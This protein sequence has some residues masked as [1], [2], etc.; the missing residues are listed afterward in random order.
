MKLTKKLESEILKVYNGYWDSYFKGDMRAFASLLHENVQLI[1]TSE[2]EVFSNKRSA[3][4]FYKATAGQVTG[5]AGMQNRKITMQVV[6]S[7]VLV[8]EQSDFYVLIDNEWSFYGNGRLS[9]LLQKTDAGWK[10]IHEHGSLPDSKTGEGE[11]VNTEKI[12]E[13]NRQLREAV[14]RRTI[15]LENK[16]RELE[17]ET[18]LERVRVVSMGMRKPDDMLDVCKTIS[19]QLQSLGVKEI[20]NVQTAI[21]YEQSGTYMNYEYYSKHKKTF[22]T[23]TDY[24]NNK[25]HKTFA[26]KMLKGKGETFTSHIKSK[27]LKEWI[28]Y[29]KTTNVFIDKY[30]NKAS[31]L[32]YY[33][34]SLGPVALGISTYHPL[35]EEE[36]DLF[37]RF[38]KVFELAYRRYLDIEKAEAQ[39][40]EAKIEAALERVR[41]RTM[42][43]QKSE[44][45]KEVIRVVY[46]QFVHLKF[47]VHHAGFVV[48][49]TAKG[50][51]HFW[52]ADEQDI[53]SKITHPYFESVWASQFNEAKEKGTDFFATKLNFEEKN[54]FYNELLSYVPGLPETSK[55]FYLS[56]P[57]LAA[58][59]VLLENVSLYIENFSGIQ[60][61][62]EENATLMR[63]GK[64]FQQTYTR[65]LDLQK[66]ET[67]AREA[68]IE[69]SLEKVR[70]VALTMKKSDE[71]LD[72]AQVLYEQLLELGFNNIRNAIIDLHNEKDKTFLDYDYSHDMGR[73]ITLM[74]YYDDPIIEKQVRQIESSSDAFFEIILE[75]QELQDLID[76]RLKNGEEE[77]PRLRQINQLTYNL[78]SFGNGAIGISNFGLLS[79]E[80]KI[81][82]KRFRN[83]FAFAYK[84]YNDMLQ[85]EAQAKESIKQASLDRVRG[86]IASMRTTEDLNRITP[87]IWRELKTLEVPFIRCGIFIVDEKQ[88]KVQVYL[89]TPDGKSLAV[90]NLPFDSNTLTKNTVNF[91]RQ[92]KVYQEHWNKEEFINWI[93]SMMDLRQVEKAETYQGSSNP[94]ES[95]H[96][97]FVPFTQ[98]MLYVGDVSPLTDE[99]L[100]LVKTLAEAFSIAYARYEDFKNLEDAKNRIEI[101]LSELKSAQTQLVHSEKMASLGELTAGIAHEIK[102]PLNFVNNFSEISGELINEIEDELQKNNKE[103]V[104]AILKDLKQN[105]ERINQHGKRADSIVKG[106][107]LHSRGTSGEKT[108][109]DI[110][111]LLDQYVILTYH[112]LRAQNSEF[113]IAIEKDYDETLGKINVVPQDISRVFLNIINNACYAAY[114]KKQK[115]KNDFH[116]ILTVSTKNLQNKVEIRI[117]DNGYGIPADVLD[118]IFQPFFT[119]K[120]TGEGTG[121]GL[122][123]SY[124]IVTKVHGGELSVETNEGEGTTFKIQLP[125]KII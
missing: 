47:N 76:M 24:T 80:H 96:L 52:I 86:E 101:T 75:G 45:L 89:T 6:G 98:G 120:P 35:T 54:K 114:D 105:L 21:F 64:V 60:Y 34:F 119:T 71:M 124:D 90:L 115:N 84:R 111:T 107:L 3:I 72:I 9:T 113:N 56:C 36:I 108:L 92:Q 74:S 100:N 10:I 91:W 99:K 13:E 58:S 2:N 53:P 32:N 28:A 82:L 12:K 77:D 18:A 95:L 73:T 65:F 62:D 43:M 110:N 55:D 109:T 17:I 102:N 118:K 125:N 78:Y 40:R 23:E 14:K 5:K 30:L 49:Y 69:A 79:D 31:S 48:D 27:K 85:A 106:M 51:W 66:A 104:L 50:N 11:Q 44:E 16:N 4:K 8:I 83:V 121:L 20:R 68:K 63:F 19:L 88:Q 123:L 94:P 103:D 93:K 81:V 117:G 70:T 41:S 112:G 1:G 67:Q 57:G 7:N 39:A 46:E 122:S 29:Q 37:K 15:E 42:G 22:I 33:W 59:T 38:L 61:S 116:P 26:E 25:I 87:I 97:H